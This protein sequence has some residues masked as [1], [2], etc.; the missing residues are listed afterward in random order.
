[1]DIDIR[2]AEQMTKIGRKSSGRFCEEFLGKS[3][4]DLLPLKHRVEDSRLVAP[5]ATNKA[6]VEKVQGGICRHLG[7]G[8]MKGALGTARCGM[9]DWHDPIIEPPRQRSEPEWRM[10][11]I[12]D[13]V[14]RG[15]PHV[16]A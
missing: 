1:M 2:I 14:E 10:W 6:P 13:A 4:N 8:E 5:S 9:A 3:R 11:R 15:L 16:A 7:R 12:A